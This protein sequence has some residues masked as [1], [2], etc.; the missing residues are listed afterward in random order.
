MNRLSLAQQA[1]S[2]S[3]AA[4]RP[5]GN[6]RCWTRVADAL[7]PYYEIVVPDSRGHGLS[8]APEFGYGVEDRAGDVAGI[9]QALGLNQPVL[10]G[11]ALGAET[12]VGT[13]ALY[14]ELVRAIVLEDP[15]WPG[16]FYGSSA[17]EREERAA[18]WRS[19]VV[20]LKKKSSEELLEMAQSQHPN[21]IAEELEPWV[22]AR[23]QVDPR[24]ANLVIAPRRRWSDYLCQANCPILLI[25]GGPSLGA[26]VSEKTVKEA[27]L[28]MSD[29]RVVNIP[30]AGHSIHREQLE[31]YIKAV[32]KFLDKDIR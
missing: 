23:K 26:T 16:R 28:F 12:A 22:E 10:I 1:A 2:G 31:A 8:E 19:E 13:A 25:T 3:H 14:P 27:R 6:G 5:N 4:P 29:G 9:I 21:W 18:S 30:G 24:I 17:E 20:E 32:R 15:P 11:H 7:H